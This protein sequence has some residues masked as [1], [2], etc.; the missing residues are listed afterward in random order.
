MNK[1]ETM[2][3]MYEAGVVAVIRAENKEKAAKIIDAV[4]EG[5]VKGI[6][7]TF[8]FDGA[9]D[10]IREYSKRDDLLV[11]AGTV[12]DKEHALLAIEAGAKY[13]VSPYFDADTAKVCVEKDIPYMPG[14]MTIN[15]MKVAFEHGASLVKLF[16]GSCFKPS[17]IK[18][19]HAPLPHFNIMPT[20]GVSLENAREWLECGACMI[21]LGGELTSP[22][23]KG[24]YAEVTRRGAALM[25]IFREFKEGK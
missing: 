2:S 24:D 11:G 6:E 13:I 21:G 8:V 7:I 4:A 23:K 10:L 5:G 17:V 9:E 19:I 22:A 25:K 14:T 3:A 16:P 15:E 20:G 1:N 18:A 12:L